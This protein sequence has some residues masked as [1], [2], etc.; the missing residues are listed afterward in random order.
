LEEHAYSV[1]I[2]DPAEDSSYYLFFHLSQEDED[3]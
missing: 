1:S 2:I 3:G